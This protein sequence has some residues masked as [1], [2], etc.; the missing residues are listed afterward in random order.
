M[1]DIK[2]IRDFLIRHGHT[3]ES[4]ENLQPVQLNELYTKEVHANT[5]DFFQFINDDES[6]TAIN[7]FDDIDIGQLTQQVKENARDTLKLIEIIRKGFDDFSYSD[8]AD[9]LTFNSRSIPAHKLQRIL[10]IAFRE[11]QEILL[12]RI[13]EQLKELPIEEY[14]VM[15]GHYENN[16]DD[17]LRLKNTIQELSIEK[18]RQQILKMA[19]LKLQIIQNFMPAYVFSDSYKEYLNNTPEKLKL[20]DEVLA[21]TG[22][23][24]KKYLKNLPIDELEEMKSKLIEDKQQD[25]RDKKIFDQYTQM[26]DESIYGSDEREFSDVCTRIITSLNQR[27][28]LM[29]TEYLNAKNPVFVNRFNTLLRDCKKAK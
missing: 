11:F 9:V 3:L 1:T 15:M 14:K 13:A 18:K 24:P 10:R 7:T 22:I 26:I 5:I 12:D 23:H 20:V 8:V 21:L 4:L 6:L 16:R 25:E 28:I 29:I 27:Q 17:I 2:A 19:H